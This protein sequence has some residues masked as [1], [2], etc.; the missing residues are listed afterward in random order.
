MRTTLMLL[1]LI[2]AGACSE[3]GS[4]QE[5]SEAGR[6]ALI[7][8]QP[9]E[10]PMGW[11]HGWLLDTKTGALEFCT[12]DVGGRPLPAGGTSRLR[13]LTCEKRIFPPELNAPPG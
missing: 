4:A 12:Y 6:F 13:T 3:P 8:V 2:L 9:G 11:F 1:T 5:A 10:S 7:P